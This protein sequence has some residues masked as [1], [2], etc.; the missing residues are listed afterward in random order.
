MYS[1]YYS[2]ECLRKNSDQEVE[3]HDVADD[4]VEDEH[5]VHRPGVVARVLANLIQIVPSWVADFKVLA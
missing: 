4:E 1:F 2:G 5:D 3:E